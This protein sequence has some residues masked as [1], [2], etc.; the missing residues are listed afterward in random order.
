MKAV[1]RSDLQM[2]Y[3]LPLLDFHF[4]IKIA[5][6]YDIPSIIT[7]PKTINYELLVDKLALVAYMQ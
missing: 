2:L 5:I 4:S 6:P 1:A 7:A 3:W